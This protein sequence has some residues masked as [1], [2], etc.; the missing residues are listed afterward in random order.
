[1]IFVLSRHA[2]LQC[3]PNVRYIPFG[4]NTAIQIFSL[5]FSRLPLID[6]ILLTGIPSRQIR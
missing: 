6:A 2:M 5:L 1:M 3:S 4:E